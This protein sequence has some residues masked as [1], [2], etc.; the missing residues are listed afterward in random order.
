MDF[1]VLEFRLI[2]LWNLVQPTS[3]KVYVFDTLGTENEFKFYYASK[4][5]SL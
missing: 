3:N 2:V 4:A 1:G 5:E